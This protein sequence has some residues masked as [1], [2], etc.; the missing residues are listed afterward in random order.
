MKF[1]ASPLLAVA[2]LCHKK[3][4]FQIAADAEKNN[5]PIARLQFSLFFYASLL[6]LLSVTKVVSAQSELPT[7][8]DVGN[9][10]FWVNV[11]YFHDGGEEKTLT[12]VLVEVP[13]GSCAFKKAGD[14]YEANV[15]VGVVFEDGSGFQI[16]GN[17][18]S[19]LIRTNDLAATRSNIRTHIFYF[20]FRVAPGNYDLRIIV[21]DEQVD[22]RFSYTCKIDIPSFTKTQLQISSL[23]LARHLEMSG[24]DSIMQK[25]GRSLIPNVPHL[26]AA[27]N[28]A[29]FFYFE[30]YNL[31]ANSSPA[32]SFQVHFRLSHQGREINSASWKI[33]KPGPIAAINLPL[34]LSGLEAGEYWLRVTVIDQDGK[35]NASAFAVFYV[36]PSV[37]PTL[38][39]FD[40]AAGSKN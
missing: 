28:R 7:G 36:A 9:R 6:V 29:G 35:R 5:S 34:H 23:L 19:D 11:L 37:A 25:N 12:E 33:P 30:A 3:R 13:Y 32:D 15:E 22:S 39:F 14:G 17:A 31:S 16:D 26:F 38:G 21:G 4:R 1:M 24:N 18:F 8:Y 10:P 2:I 27:Q 40:A 20:A